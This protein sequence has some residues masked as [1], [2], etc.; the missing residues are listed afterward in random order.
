MEER[1]E[2]EDEEIGERGELDVAADGLGMRVQGVHRYYHG[3]DHHD[4]GGEDGEVQDFAEDSIDW[5]PSDVRLLRSE[6]SLR[7]NEVD[8]V[9][10]Q[11]AGVDEDSGRDC[12]TDVV[13][14]VRPHDA[15][16]E[17]GDAGHGETEQCPR[18]HELVVPAAID[19]QYRHVCCSECDEDGNE[20]RA[21][22]DIGGDR[23]QLSKASC[24]GGIWT[25]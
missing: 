5:I 8:D 9:D 7:K 6:D 1:E 16:N 22:W 18:Y 17:S 24:G 20:H 23:R 2:G 19:L 12:K 15:Q 25:P 4:K 11:D 13:V 3:G 21:D 10:D 14:S